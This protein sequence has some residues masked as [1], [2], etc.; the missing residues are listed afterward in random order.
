M[1]NS[2]SQKSASFE[3]AHGWNFENRLTAKDFSNLLFISFG[4]LP[5]LS[6]TP[7]SYCSRV[8]QLAGGLAVSSALYA[9][10]KLDI[11]DLLAQG[12]RSV[13]ELATITGS[14]EDALYRV[15]RALGNV[16][17]FSETAGRGFGPTPV[18]EILREGVAGSA[19]EL[20]LWLGNRFH[21]H[22]WAE[23]PYSVKTGKPAVEHVYGKPAFEAMAAQP[24][25]AHDFNRGMTGLS[26]RLAPAVL[27]AYDF[28]G[29]ETLMDV[30]G[31]HGFI[32]CDIINKYPELKG[33]LFDFESVLQDAK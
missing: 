17:V 23:L 1:R 22:V 14:N 25:V 26:R 4:L 24:D 16:G 9:A 33:I 30:A 32:L 31:G 19:K 3:W 13:S 2:E 10:T 8:M 7:A 27:E 15:L 20:V 12:A 5:G 29:I 11:P 21:F 18:S 28:S 6:D